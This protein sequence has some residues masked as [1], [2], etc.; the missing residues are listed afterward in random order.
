MMVSKKL[1]LATTALMLAA[2]AAHASVTTPI[3][4]ISFGPGLTD[5]TNATQSVNLFNTTLGTLDSFTI[6]VSYGFNSVIT[7]SNQ[8]SAASNGSVKTESAAG[9]G[10]TN[11]AANSILD[12]IVDTNGPATVGQLTLANS[13]YDQ[14]GGVN[15]YVVNA[16]SSQTYNSNKAAQTLGPIVDSTASD[17]QAFEAAG[18]GALAIL[19]NTITGTDQT[20]TAGN[21]SSTQSTTATGVF[22]IFYTY[23]V[24]P[25]VGVPEPAS[26]AILGAGLIFTG[27]IRRHRS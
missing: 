19:F 7:I 10:S 27:L 9:F 14:L 23:D 1:A 17:L 13:A 16:N 26:M 3:Q 25:P 6:T 15:Q 18:G 5:Y 21:S 22:K 2:G 12:N 11:S 4:T 24:A 8:G 20:N